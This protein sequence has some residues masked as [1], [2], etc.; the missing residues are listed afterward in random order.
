MKNFSLY[1]FFILLISLYSQYNL[2]YMK[3]EYLLQDLHE[4]KDKMDLYDSIVD[5][6]GHF[7]STDWVCNNLFGIS[8]EDLDMY[9]KK[10]LAKKRLDLLYG[11]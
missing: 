7:F 1:Y 3:K 2:K 10:I 4:L 11:L 6:Y 8:K 5:N 9:N